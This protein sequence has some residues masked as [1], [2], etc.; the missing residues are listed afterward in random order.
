[1]GSEPNEHE[2]WRIAQSVAWT[3]SGNDV[4][5]LDLDLPTP[6]PMVLGQSAAYIW[7]E[8]ALGG[9]L[10]THMLTQRV[11]SAYEVEEDVVRDD[12]LG[13]LVTLVE[14]RLIVSDS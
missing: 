8:I 9:P 5:V 10:T 13:L 1:M 12:V 3:T 11:A 6:T 14:Q 4:V 2:R 7:E